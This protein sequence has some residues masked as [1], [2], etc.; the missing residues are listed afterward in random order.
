[1]NVPRS[2]CKV[3]H[4]H[5]SPGQVV[6]SSWLVTCKNQNHWA[7]LNIAIHIFTVKWPDF[8]DSW[9]LV[10]LLK[11]QWKKW[12]QHVSNTCTYLALSCSNSVDRMSSSLFFWVLSFNSV[13]YFWIALLLLASFSSINFSNLPTRS[14]ICGNNI[15]HVIKWTAARFAIKLGDRKKTR[16]RNVKINCKTSGGVSGNWRNQILYL[17]SKVD[18]SGFGRNVVLV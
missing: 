12:L 9:Q 11:P 7:L 4:L 15:Q 10:M 5:D 17:E 6:S 1:M 13:W 16:K 3:L 14:R 8:H 2:E 18:C